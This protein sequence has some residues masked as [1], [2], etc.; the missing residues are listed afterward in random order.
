L[1]ALEFVGDQF[2]PE[3][4]ELDRWEHEWLQTTKL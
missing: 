1:Y 2:N 3:R 4:F